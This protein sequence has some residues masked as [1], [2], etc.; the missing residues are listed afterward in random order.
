MI[1][2]PC[3][4]SSSKAD[5]GKLSDNPVP[6]LKVIF[7]VEGSSTRIS[8]TESQSSSSLV[9]TP[10]ILCILRFSTKAVNSGA[11]DTARLIFLKPYEPSR[12]VVPELLDVLEGEE[13]PRE[14]Q[15]LK[16][17][18]GFLAAEGVTGEDLSTVAMAF[19]GG[20]SHVVDN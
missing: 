7:P 18:D 19:D 4:S 11:Y 5:A 12:A 10:V 8:T 14:L 16:Q 1:S 15:F 3:Y 9:F 13:P 17:L 20:E 6:V 2:L